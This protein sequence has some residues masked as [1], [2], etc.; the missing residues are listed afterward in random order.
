MFSFISLGKPLLWASLLKPFL[1]FKVSRKARRK[2]KSKSLSDKEAGNELQGDLVTV[3]NE[4]EIS[5]SEQSA[6]MSIAQKGSL[7]NTN[8]HGKENIMFS[9]QAGEPE[10]SMSDTGNLKSSLPQV[11]NGSAD[12]GNDDLC[13]GTGD[14]SGDE[15]LDATD[16]VDFKV[17]SLISAFANNNII[18]KLCWLLKFYKSNS[19]S[20]NH[21]IICLLRRITDDLEL[22][23]M[24]Y[25]VNFVIYSLL[26]EKENAWMSYFSKNNNLYFV[27]Q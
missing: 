4:I 5:N 20:T 16:E 11:D 8:P 7:T 12:R 10:I 19:A 1:L 26:E 13:Y 22:S 9:A 25:Q 3:Q 6:D 23:P 18:H 2:R 24:L 17:S 27:G 14:S 15:Q 21:Y